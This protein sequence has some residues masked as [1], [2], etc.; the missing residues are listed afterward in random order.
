MEKSPVLQ[1]KITK[2]RKN[3]RLRNWQKLVRLAI[4]SLFTL[5]IAL[6]FFADPAFGQESPELIRFNPQEW[7]RNALQWIDSLGAVGAIAIK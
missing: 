3:I 7:L 5:G 4:L 6:M 1:P 2:S